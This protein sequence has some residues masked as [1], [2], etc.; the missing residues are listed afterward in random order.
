MSPLG[1]QVCLDLHKHGSENQL[2][3]IIKM[4]YKKKKQG[5]SLQFLQGL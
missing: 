2:K 1:N 5:N 3:P 4:I